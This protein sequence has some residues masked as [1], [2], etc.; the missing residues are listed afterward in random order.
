MI[1]RYKATIKGNRVFM[2]EYEIESSMTLFKLRS[3][4][5]N[6]LGF[7]QDQLTVFETISADGSVMRRIGLFDMGDGT[8]DR[9]TVGD[10]VAREEMRIRYVYNLSMGYSILMENMGEEVFNPRFSYP[11]TVA[12]KGRNPDQFSSEYEDFMEGSMPVYDAED[13][14]FDEEELPEGEEG[15]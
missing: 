4:L 10:C 7:S 15:A 3:F 8:M 14:A 12:E 9:I 1:Y 2:R 5:N 13:A 11:V 6:D